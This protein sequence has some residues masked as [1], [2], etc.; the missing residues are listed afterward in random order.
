MMRRAFGDAPGVSAKGLPGAPSPLRG[1]M[2]A[3]T[4]VE[5]DLVGVEALHFQALCAQR[6]TFI[7]R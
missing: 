1:S 7:D 3:M 4:A 6:A 2:R 5:P